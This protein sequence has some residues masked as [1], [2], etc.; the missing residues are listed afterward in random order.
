MNRN[1]GLATG[2]EWW[3]K[4]VAPLDGPL[5]LI[6]GLLMLLAVGLMAS[7]SPERINA[8]L[9]NMAVALVVMRILA[10]IPPQRL[11]HLAVPIYVAGVLLL[12]AVALFGD[13]SKGA[14][15]WLNLGFMRAQPSELMKIAMPLLLAWFFQQR[16]AMPGLQA[17]EHLIAMSPTMERH[18]LAGSACK[19]L[20]IIESD[21]GRE[22]DALAAIARMKRHTAA[23]EKIARDGASP[24]LHYPALNRLA[25]ELASDAARSDWPGFDEH[26]L[27][28]VRHS[29][30][31][32]TRDDP[33]FWSVAG[34]TE[35]RMMQAVAARALAREAEP[36]AAEF[37]ALHARVSAPKDWRSVHDSARFVLDRYARRA[38]SGD[39]RA[40]REIVELLEDFAWPV[41]S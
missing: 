29:L 34:L 21:A 7:A 31:E 16:E 35:L 20:A 15:R 26:G 3:H 37:S 40:C 10:Q 9:I 28:A 41:G 38:A 30:I 5:M 11:M 13:V 24:D 6:A 2:R 27:A 39:Q 25:A 8:Q 1:F 32:H 33:D 36:I 23:A 4:L 22:R 14:R 17:I 19:R 12:V 18:S